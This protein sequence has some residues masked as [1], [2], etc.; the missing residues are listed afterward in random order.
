M[1]ADL[2]FALRMLAR[3]PGFTVVALLTLALGIGANTAIFSVINA[4]LLRPLP[5]PEADRIV[6]FEGE[7]RPHGITDSNISVPDFQDWAA[8]SHAFS[9]TA[10]FWTGSAALSMQG[11]EPERVPRA[12]V[13]SAFFNL[14]GVQP[15]LGRS[16]LPADDQ[17]DTVTVAILGERLWKRRFGSNPDIV[18]KMI[19]INAVPLTI[20]GVMPAGFEFPE[21][22]QIWTPSGVNFAKEPRDNRSYSVLGR[23]N[24][25]VGLAEV[26]SQISAIN[27]RLAQAFPDTNKGWDAHVALLHE[28][29]VRSVRPSLL[30]L[31]GAVGC[32]L[33]I[34]CANIANLLLVRAAARQK[35]LAIRAA[36][37]A[38]WGRIVQQ[39]LTE[40]ILLSTIGGGLGLLLSFWL[41][42]LLIS[43][44]PPDSPRFSETNLDYRVLAFTLAI[45]VFTGIIF[46]LA[47][48]LQ[49]SRLDVT[50]SLKEGGRTGES[51]RR[52]NV[53]SLLLI[54]EVAMSL[55]LLVG[56]GLLIK[57]F[58]RLQ[59]VKP[60]FNPE[61]VLIASLSLPVAK[62]KEDQQRIDFYRAFTER[63][64]ALPG[65]Q[66]AGAGV[67]L[68]LRASNYSIGRSFIPEGRPL[69]A[70]ESVD[71]SWSTI[72]PAY[73]EALQIPLLAGRPF[74]ERDNASALK[75]VIVNRQVAIK[76]FG[77]ETAAIGKRITIWRDET[78]PREIVGVVGETKPAALEEESG[79]QI[80]TP[81]SQDGSWGF[82]TLAIRTTADPAAMTNTLRREVME[83]DKDLP[84]FNVRTMEDVVAA[85]MGSRRV[86]MSLFAI[87][88]IAALLLAAVGIYGVMAYS[89]TQR[90]HEI[91]VRM[92][93]GAQRSDMLQMVLWQSFSLVGIGLIAGLLSSLLLTRL[94]TSLLY[95][96]VVHDF[97][98][99]VLVLI[100]LSG[101]AFLAT[102]LPARRAASV[103]P[104]IALRAE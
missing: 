65:V 5:Y 11:G 57:S 23:L 100:V 36:L 102:W 41:I 22:T 12:G 75:V 20:V 14:L 68:P 94:M 3:N 1:I 29:L 88:A 44:G 49:A 59:E 32:V 96:V 40:S 51:Y 6:Y 90:T 58:M 24:P 99:Y 78:F 34:A 46:G 82:M 81:H 35:E 31:L 27:A 33:L 45:S 37:G 55:I 104:A 48:A 87:F 47:P 43:I 79:A 10:F 73:F 30:I 25:G 62:Y 4:V 56:A 19:T 71:S 9:Q 50:N 93:L 83:L 13:S 16:F 63:I 53:R 89:T 95:G 72:T 67:N 92:A 18:G 52:T 38:A 86:S 54:G 66:A 74:N 61:R 97:S 17:P 8:Q 84:I 101:A 64:D 103:D 80:Y 69:T 15:M 98:I 26:Q 77:S 7:N 85:S 28:R 42:E 21:K 91:G 39:M 2:K 76:Y 70:D 60:G